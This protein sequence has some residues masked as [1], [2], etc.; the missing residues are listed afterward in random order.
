GLL[1]VT[2]AKGKDTCLKQCTKPKRKRDDSWFK[3]KVLLVQAQANSQILHEEELAFLA[4]PGIAKGQ[5]TQTIITHNATYQADNLDAYDF[6]CDELNTAKVALMANLSHY[7]SDALAEVNNN[8][9]VDN[10]LMNQVV[11]AMSSSEQLTVVNNSETEITSDSNIIPYSQK[12]FF[13]NYTLKDGLKET[14]SERLL[15]DNDVQNHTIDSRKKAAVLRGTANVQHSKLNANSELKCVKC[16]GCMLSDN[17]DLCV[18][19]F[20]NNVNARVKSKSIKKSSKRKVWKPTG[21]VFIN[22]GYIWR[23]IGRTIT[24]VGNVCPLTRITTTTEVPLRKPTILDNEIPKPVEPIQSWGSIVSDVPSSSLDECKS[25]KLFSVK[26]RNDHV[27]KILGYGDYQIGN[28]TISRVYYVEGLGHN[29]FSVGQFY[30]SNL[31]VA[32]RQHTCFIHNLE[33][34]DLFTVSRGN[35]LYTLSLRDMMSSSLI[36]LLSSSRL[37]MAMAPSS[38]HYELWC[39]QHIA[40]Q[41]CSRLT[42]LEQA[43]KIRF[44]RTSQVSNS[45]QLDDKDLEQIDHDDLEEIDL[46]WECRAPRNQGNRNGDAGYRSRDNTRRIVP[47]E[48]SDALV[49]Q[50]N[51]LIVQ[52]GLG[53]DW[54]YI[55]QD[56]PTKFALM[57]YTTNSSGSDTEANLEIIAYQLGLE[58]VEAQ[59]VVHQK[60]EAIY[61]EKIAVLEFEVKDK[62]LIRDQ[63]NKN[64]SSG[65]ELFNSVFDSRSSDGDDN[66][67]NDR[68]K[69]D[70]GYHVVPPPLKGTYMPPYHLIKLDFHD[71]RMAKKSVLKNMG[72]NT[73]QREI[74]LVWNSAQ[75]I[76]HQNKFVS[77]AVLTRSGRVPVSTAKQSSLRA[78]ASMYIQTVIWLPYNRVNV[79]ILRTNAFHKSHSPIRRPF[80]K[81]TAPNTSISNEKVNTVRVIGGVNTRGKQLG[82]FRHMTGNKELPYCFQELDGGFVAFV[83]ERKNKTLIEA[84]RTMLADSLLPTVFWAKVVNTACYVLNSVFSDRLITRNYDLLIGKPPSISFMRPF[85]CPVTILNTVDPLGKFDGKD[86]EGFLV[87]YSIN[88]KAIKVFNSQTRK[89]KEN[90][91]VNFLEN[92]LNV[93]RQGP[94]W[95]FDIDSLINSMNYQPVTAGN[96]TNKNAGPQEANG[97]TALKQ[98][99][100]NEQALKNVLDKMMDQEKEATKQSDV[101]RKEFEAQCNKE[102]FQGKDTKASNTNSF[103]IVRTPVN[104]AG[105]S[106]TS[107]DAGPSSVPLGIFGSAFD[108]EDL[109]TYNSPLFDQVK[110]PIK[111]AQALDEERWVEAMQEELLQFKIQKVFDPIAR[112]EAIRLFLAYASFMNFVMYH[113]DVKSAF[114]YGTIEEEVP[115]WTGNPQQEVVNFLVQVKCFGSKIRCWIMV[116]NQSAICVVKNPV[117]H[118][119]T[120]HIEIMHHFIRDSYEKRLIEMVKIHTDNNV[121]D[122]LTKAFDGRLMVFKCS[123]VYTSAIWIEVGMDYNWY[124]VLIDSS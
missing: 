33:G 97:N 47:V 43:K 101:V 112:I 6:D 21:K 68:F 114:L 99:S 111:I 74:R 105:A 45:P 18:L 36:C 59:L 35:N 41:V 24:I 22:I 88:N 78:I 121:A 107:N 56:E 25:S 52:D 100:E 4:D 37:R 82:M 109:D 83:A 86:E 110:E 46:K 123:G 12:K 55:A 17:H 93:A 71:K 89:G 69:K 61:E 85:G 49:V 91:H 44:I 14:L 23:P 76:N 67:T 79:S 65:S 13:T 103:N 87:G 113:M 66:Q 62:S 116:D 29:L 92:K 58:S 40:R 98:T 115:V 80:H 50:D 20:I 95:L 15:V 124:V 42:K 2:T 108:D 34:V 77:F 54:S 75:R 64:D 7:C 51:A 5:A 28:V 11:Q 90:L 120:K 19:E 117:Y 118:S 48:T 57:A 53:Y 1:F 10:N 31:E 104:G 27:A 122:L 119:K 94:N 39:N 102:L 3:D 73:G 96:Q 26:F 63:L 9:N 81:S 60:N 8:D 38:S 16:N 70:N 30:D 32:F 84:A 72:K 106:R